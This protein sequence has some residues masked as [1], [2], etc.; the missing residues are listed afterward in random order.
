MLNWSI[1]PIMAT[2]PAKASRTLSG[3]VMFPPVP[4]GESVSEASVSFATIQSRMFIMPPQV[5]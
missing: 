2:L 4:G 3:S 1:P 5:W